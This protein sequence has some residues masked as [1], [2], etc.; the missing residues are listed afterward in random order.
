[1]ELLRVGVDETQ[2]LDRNERLREVGITEPELARLLSPIGLDLG[3]CTPDE[4]ALSIASEIVSARCG[5]NGVSLTSAR[6][7]IHPDGTPTPM[8][9]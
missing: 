8:L 6:G 7:S 3:A 4:T 5:G 1:M 2:D 9:R